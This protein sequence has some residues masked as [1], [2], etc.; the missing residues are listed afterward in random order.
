[1][2]TDRL[3]HQF[4]LLFIVH[5]NWQASSVSPAI[6]NASAVYIHNAAFVFLIKYLYNNNV[7]RRQPQNDM[8]HPWQFD[9]GIPTATSRIILK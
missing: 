7:S 5:G 3:D 6:Y 1:M 4:Q 8:P 9:V 2:I